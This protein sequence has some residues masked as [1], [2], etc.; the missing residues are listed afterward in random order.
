MRAERS[1][2]VVERKWLVR[3]VEG[4]AVGLQRAGRPWHVVWRFK[5]VG[6][7]DGRSYTDAIA[8]GRTRFC[9]DSEHILR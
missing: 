6:C 3:L 2:V 7:G 1:K 8:R 9:F 4:L 5:R